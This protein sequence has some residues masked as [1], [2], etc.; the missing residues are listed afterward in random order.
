ML[1]SRN[2][3]DAWLTVRRGAACCAPTTAQPRA[4]KVISLELSDPDST[5]LN[6]DRD[7]SL[8]SPDSRTI[9]SP[10]ELHSGSLRAGCDSPPAV[11]W[12]NQQPAKRLKFVSRA[13]FGEIPKPTVFKH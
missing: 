13:R 3:L 4:E 10:L 1:E 5:N 2:S 11:N 9:L 6:L 8:S 12:H 7:E